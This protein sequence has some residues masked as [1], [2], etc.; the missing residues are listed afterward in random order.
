MTSLE[1]KPTKKGFGL[2]I[3][4]ESTK[5]WILF[6][7]FNK[8]KVIDIDCKEKVRRQIVDTFF[9]TLS[10][11][12]PA[13]EVLKKHLDN[14]LYLPDV[15]R[16]TISQ[17]ESIAPS[18]NEIQQ[19]EEIMFM[20]EEYKRPRYEEVTINQIENQHNLFDQD[21]CS[22]VVERENKEVFA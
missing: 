11:I 3:L 19:T 15:V 20:D 6:T 22:E 5:F 10:P 9:E 2:D 21:S 17:F 8:H 13:Q 1:P 16:E 4:Q 18:L 12:K 7:Y 14:L